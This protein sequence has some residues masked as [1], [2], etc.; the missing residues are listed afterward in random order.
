M[1][2]EV[3]QFFLDLGKQSILAVVVIAYIYFDSK[4]KRQTLVIKDDERK[5]DTTEVATELK[6]HEVED[7]IAIALLQQKQLQLESN[8]L[9]HQEAIEDFMKR[10]TCI[11]IKVANKLDIN[12]DELF[13]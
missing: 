9:K 10:M 6:A 13:K 5:V 7:D 12:A 2:S 8:H 4:K 1:E 3:I 11:M